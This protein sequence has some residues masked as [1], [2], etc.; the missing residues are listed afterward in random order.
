[1]RTQIAAVVVLALLLAGCGASSRQI[2]QPE[3]QKKLQERT[4]LGVLPLGVDLMAGAASTTPTPLDRRGRDLFYRLFG[5]TL[6]DLSKLTVLEAGPSY[7]PDGVT[8]VYRRLTLAKSDT[9]EVP[10]PATGPVPVEGRNPAFLLF[11]DDLTFA[12][13]TQEGREALGTLV[14]EQLVMRVTCEY[15]LWDNRAQRLVGYGRLEET[16]PME[17]GANVRAPISVLLH[18]LGAAI[19]RKS[20]FVLIGVDTEV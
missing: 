10:V 4:T 16:A 14:T 15:V 2:L 17:A 3:Y 5:L 12:F 1:M 13:G 6:N 9:V 18:R 20:P 19:I 11:I 7:E 8:F